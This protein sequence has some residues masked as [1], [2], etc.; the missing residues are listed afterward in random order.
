MEN[1]NDKSKTLQ[2]NP[3]KEEKKHLNRAEGDLYSAKRKNNANIREEKED[4]SGKILI[5]MAIILA[6]MLIAAVTV[7]IMIL[8]KDNKKAEENPSEIESI[9][10]EEEILP[11]EEEKEEEVISSYDIVFYGDS[12]IKKEDYYSVLADLYDSSFNKKDNRK[13]IINEETDIRENGKRL[14][15]EGLIYAIESM[16]GEGI[17]FEGKIRESDNVLLSVSYEG[18]FREE[19]EEPSEEETQKEEIIPEEEAPENNE[20]EPHENT[21]PSEGIVDGI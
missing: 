2:F 13:L 1:N 15:A 3:L 12:V 19:A 17:I 8:S 14:S 20:E 7:G 4:K 6:V 5:Y 18:S 21:E 16:A 11:E 10:E 9:I